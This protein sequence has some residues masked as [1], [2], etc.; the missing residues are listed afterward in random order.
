MSLKI[1][2]TLD[3]VLQEQNPQPEVAEFVRSVVG[4]ECFE[5]SRHY[6]QKYRE[7]LDAALKHE[8]QRG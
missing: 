5:N 3:E 4:F 2:K 8:Q 6:K 7:F 1:L